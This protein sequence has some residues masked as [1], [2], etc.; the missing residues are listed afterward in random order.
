MHCDSIG[1]APHPLV[2]GKGEECK[3]QAIRTAIG[4]FVMIRPLG[5]NCVVDVG[6]GRCWAALCVEEESGAVGLRYQSVHN[7]HPGT[8]LGGGDFQTLHSRWIPRIIQST[9]HTNWFNR[10]FYC[11]QSLTVEL[12]ILN[13]TTLTYVTVQF[14]KGVSR[15]TFSPLR[16]WCRFRNHSFAGLDPWRIPDPSVA[17]ARGDPSWT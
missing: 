15:A 1:G 14:H 3:S 2:L 5:G 13:Y 10:S 7:E 8:A 9:I 12:N 17:V 11:Q 4:G 6:V 16:Q